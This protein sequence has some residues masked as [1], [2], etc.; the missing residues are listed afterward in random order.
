MRFRTYLSGI[1]MLS[2]LAAGCSDPALAPSQDTS[3]PPPPT[4][5]APIA[6][7]GTSCVLLDCAFDAAGS[8][9]PDGGISSYDWNFGDGSVATGV[10]ASHSYSAAGAYTISLTVTDNGGATGDGSQ[11]VTVVESGQSNNPPSA[12]FSANC[13]DLSCNFDAGNSTDSDGTIVGYDWSYGDGSVGTGQTSSHSFGS[14]GTY[15]V[16]L[17]VTDNSGATASTTQSLSVNGPVA[18]P[19][20]ETLFLQKCSTCHGADALGGT[21]ARI[22]IVGKTAAEITTAIAT[23]R[24]MSS[25]ITL[26]AEEIQA[27]ADHLAT[28]VTGT[29]Q[30][31]GSTWSKVTVLDSNGTTV[32]T[33]SDLVTGRYSVGGATL[34]GSILA[35]A[36]FPND[37]VT[38]YGFAART[39]VLN[40]TLLTDQIVKASVS[41]EQLNACFD[42]TAVAEQCLVQLTPVNTAFNQAL[43]GYDL[44]QLFA[45]YGVDGLD[46]WMNQPF[47]SANGGMSAII[48]SVW[49]QA[50]LNC[51]NSTG[52]R[53]VDQINM[54]AGC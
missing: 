14:D 35:R 34:S 15:S 38:L 26:T 27:I 11:A 13:T 5:S 48:R 39:G 46:S 29:T 32:D 51:T 43:L 49:D 30:S 8:S 33:Q 24:N 1:L 47:D 21:L 18:A 42:G 16:A 10:T 50:V 52:S 53:F 6:V 37:G 20:G 36:Y 44:Q 12:S 7:F 45:L 17:T 54:D 41:G 9:D 19:D 31:G 28:L 25:L 4:N 40:I 22:S 3:T 23:I 2:A